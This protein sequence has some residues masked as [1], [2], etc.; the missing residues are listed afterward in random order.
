MDTSLDIFDLKDVDVAIAEALKN[1]DTLATSKESQ[2]LI[3][4]TGV[5]INSKP[6]KDGRYQG[7]ILREG[8]KKYLYGASREEVATKIKIYLKEEQFPKKKKRQTTQT[9]LLKDFANN[10]AIAYKKPNLKPKS[11]ESVLHSLSHAVKALG[12]KQIGK[13]TT[14][15]LQTFFV[16]MGATRSRDLCY[17]YL[18]QLFTHAEETR[19]IKYNP[20]KSVRLTKHEAEIRHALTPQEQQLFL[21]ETQSSQYSLLFRFL[22]STGLRIGEA[23]ALTASDVDGKEKTVT[24]SKDIVFL[25]NGKAV[26][27]QPKSR[28]AY[29][30]VP[31]P[32]NICAELAELQTERLFPFTYNSV[33]H[34][35]KRAESQLGFSVSAHILRHTYATRLEE[36]GIP[37]KIKQYL[38]GHSSLRMTQDTYTDTQSH[39]VTA[40]SDRVRAVFDTK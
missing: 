36:A 33:R 15:E 20:M 13:I 39:Y 12:D 18:N 34:A 10:W 22:L 37:P 19:Q 28:A 6:R 27:Q 7:Y 2:M 23:L 4:M 30:T 29:R 35:F 17:T 24:V 31:V 3:N 5:S 8:E 26:I 40:Q 38:M 16:G 9:L 25:E 14:D 32:E 21:Q 1:G 11:Y